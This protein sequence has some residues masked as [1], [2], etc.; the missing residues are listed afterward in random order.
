M[1]GTDRKGKERNENQRK[2][3]KEMKWGKRG[4]EKQNRRGK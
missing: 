3:E 1:D 4:K 2:G